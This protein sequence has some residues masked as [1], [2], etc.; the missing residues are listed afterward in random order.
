[1]IQV[2]NYIHGAFLTKLILTNM[3]DFDYT[4]DFPEFGKSKRKEAEDVFKR[5]VNEKCIAKFLE[6]K[7]EQNLTR[8]NNNF[9][10]IDHTTKL[11]NNWKIYEKVKP[12]VDNWNVFNVPACL[13]V[14]PFVQEPV[15][16]NETMPALVLSIAEDLRKQYPDSITPDPPAKKVKQSHPMS[17]NRCCNRK[18]GS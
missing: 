10:E 5:N 16:S 8:T 18:Q 9:L 11:F 4:H 14:L 13:A 15:E 6:S 12:M 2:F 1:M 7:A 17:Y 3:S